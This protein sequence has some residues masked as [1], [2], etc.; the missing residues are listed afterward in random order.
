M[1]IE[2]FAASTHRYR[3][4]IDGM[5]AVA[6]LLVFAYHLGTSYVKGGYV[7]VDVF[8]VI[9]GYLIGSI[10]LSEIDAGKFSLL[11]FYERRI[12]RILPALF[13]TL[14]ACAI[15]AY[16]LFLP[17][18]LLE[19]AKSYLAAT[20]SVANVF[21]YK[22]SGYFEGAASM[23]PLLHTW[24]LAVE[25]Q[26]YVFLPLFLLALRRFTSATRR[27]AVVTVALLSF[28]IS[29]RGAFHNPD[30]TFYLAHTRA[31]EL[32]LGTLIALDALPSINGVWARNAWSAIGLASVF[33]SAMFYEK[34]TPFPGLAAALPCFGTAMIIAA[35]REGDSF[36]SRA[37]SFRPVV[38]IG[39]ISYSLYLWHWPLIVFQ[40]AS[41]LLVQGLS[42]RGSK[43]VVLSIAFIVAALS[44]RFVEQPFR[45]TRKAISRNRLFQLASTAAAALTL[46]GVIAVKTRGFPSRYPDE[47]VKVASF[48]ENGDPATQAQYRVGSCFLTSRNPNAVFARDECL[49]MDPAKRND[50]LIG[51]SHAAQLWFGLSSTFPEI[52][53]LQATA[54]GCKP[55]FDQPVG[56]DQRCT[57]LMNYALREYLSSH[58]V[59]AV[60]LAARWDQY[61]L[62]RLRRTVGILKKNGARVIIFGPVVQY[63]SALPR[64]LAISIKQGN[65]FLPASHRVAFY[66]QLDRDMRQLAEQELGVKYISFFKL[67]C[68]Q[69]DCLEY[70]A[71]D[72]PLQSDYGHLTGEGS[73]V[74][75][76]RLRSIG[77][78]Q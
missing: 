7:G 63:D 59:D 32:L 78:L 71:K 5:R 70:A 72:V 48:L 53:F 36:V 6:V 39:T 29:A 42:P 25:E 22:Q 26:F 43:L 3:A 49:R 12:R 8:F 74:V 20:F 75:A 9:S 76:K 2:L 11:K 51:D 21:F 64:L 44:W 65:P 68:S 69:D 38:F 40:N 55:A 23:K 24:S 27:A 47:A 45:N 56:A 67:I 16:K 66:R 34:T 15:L 37:L 4:D 17:S 28:V 33:A 52:N 14:A 73:I 46:F 57:D 30:A 18:E 60:L 10:I 77:A 41:G 19:F 35:G 50:L 58:R 31:W 62:P 1:K 61:D 13:V 54:S